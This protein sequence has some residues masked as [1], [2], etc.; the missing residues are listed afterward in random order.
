MKLLISIFFIFLLNFSHASDVV[1]GKIVKTKHENYGT[2]Y[3]ILIEKQ[4]KSYAYPID[5]QSNIKN[6]HTKVNKTF[7]IYGESQFVKSTQGEGQFIVY[8]KINQAEELKLKDLAL[9]EHVDL[10]DPKILQTSENKITTK[11]GKI[12]IDDATA[13]KAILI[14]GAALAAEILSQILR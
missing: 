14:G 11:D 6:I 12:I 13:N 10:Q 8:Y 3:F 5:P 7:K 1:I 2:N 4:D 9:K